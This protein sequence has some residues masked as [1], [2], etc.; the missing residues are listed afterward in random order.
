MKMIMKVGE[1]TGHLMNKPDI[2]RHR[3]NH[4]GQRVL[5]HLDGGVG[6]KDEGVDC[7]PVGRQHVVYLWVHP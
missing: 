4:V 6:D 3:S 2:L 7:R 1:L 5:L